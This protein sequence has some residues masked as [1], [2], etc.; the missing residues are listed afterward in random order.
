[1]KHR[2]LCATVAFT[3]MMS[4]A[5]PALAWGR[6]GHR[7]IN[8]IAARALPAII[9]QFLRTAAA[10]DEIER[11]GPEPDRLKDAGHIWDAEH[12]TGHFINI[13]DDG[14]V[15][16]IALTA[17]PPTREAFDTQLR[18]DGTTQY[19]EGYLP[20]ELADG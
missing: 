9:P 16:G 4:S 2:L 7:I 6:V 3:L 12:D 15:D 10:A 18:A 5:S 1:M 20:Y 8:G 17:L 11:L 19:R 13:R 14:T